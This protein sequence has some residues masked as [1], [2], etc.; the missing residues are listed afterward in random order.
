MPVSKY[1]IINVRGG[2]YCAIELNPETIKELEKQLISADN[3]CYKCGK[4]GHFAAKC[5][6]NKIVEKVENKVVG[7]TSNKTISTPKKDYKSKS[8]LSAYTPNAAPVSHSI[9]FKDLSIKLG[10]NMCWKCGRKSH[11]SNEC[12][13]NTDINGDKII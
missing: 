2:T 10:I 3:A 12:Y 11:R 1:G 7:K 6:E 5:N 9:K 13:A 8:T 4:I